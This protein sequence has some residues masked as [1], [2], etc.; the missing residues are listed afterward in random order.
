MKATLSVLLLLVS[1]FLFGQLKRTPEQDSLYAEM[2]RNTN[3]D[4]KNM[5]A[6]LGIST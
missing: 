6:Q 2:Q 3:L 4:H 1:Q 5:M